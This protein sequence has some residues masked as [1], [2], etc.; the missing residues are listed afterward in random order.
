MREC[1][2][3]EDVESAERMIPMMPF[4][5]LLP[6][7]FACLAPRVPLRIYIVVYSKV[8]VIVSPQCK[9]TCAACAIDLR[10]IAVVAEV[11]MCFIYVNVE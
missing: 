4:Y 6:V 2:K 1:R 8:A 3:I 9:R 10:Q 7:D 11:P 5:E